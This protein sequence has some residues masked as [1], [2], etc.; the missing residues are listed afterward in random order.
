MTSSVDVLIVG[1]G[2]AGLALAVALRQT[3]LSLALVE[4]RSPQ[5][6]STPSPTSES[7]DAR[8]YAISPSNARFLDDMG[9]WSRLHL[10]PHDTSH[11]IPTRITPIEQMVV[12]GDA[13]GRI[14]FSAYESHVDELGWIVESSLLQR[15]LWETARRQGN[16]TLLCPTRP[17]TLQINTSGAQLQLEDGRTLSA[18]L[19]VA[20]DGADSWTR[21]AAGIDVQFQPYEQMGVVANF[22]CSQ[23]HH[24]TAF[25]WFRR[26]GVLAWLPL[27]GQR[28]SMVWST[29]ERHARELLALSP[30][31]LCQ[32]V[33]AA[34]EKRLGDL[35]LLTPP[36]AFPLR[37]MRAPK[38]VAPRLAL[39]GDA[40]HTIHPLSGHGINLGFKDAQSLADCLLKMPA[41]I[42]CGDLRL[43]RQY[44]RSRA[45]EIIALQSVTHALQ[46]LFQPQNAPLVWLRNAGLN[47]THA[48][49]VIKQGLIRY[50]LG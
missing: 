22:I 19:V 21:Q 41:H 50:A 34:G 29:P 32:H 49:P 8:I 36:A 9:I 23:A 14:D 40:A 1:G 4:T 28:I 15:E 24:G 47:L 20:A 10:H 13:G 46:R 43:L 35:S 30:E 2:L 25:Q 16:L 37:L 11:D 33:A 6:L 26:D 39:I 7:W 3:S 12:K 45:E 5:S 42:D 44:E 38:L 27:P 18:R 31:A 17:Q 48:L